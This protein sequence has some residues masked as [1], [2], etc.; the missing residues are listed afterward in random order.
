MAAVERPA[1]R[2]RDGWL[3]WCGIT[4]ECWSWPC[5]SPTSPGAARAGAGWRPPAGT[6]TSRCGWIPRRPC[7]CCS[8]RCS[9]CSPGRCGHGPRWSSSTWRWRRRCTTG[10]RATCCRS[11][12]S[13]SMR[14]I[15]GCSSSPPARSRW[16][17][18]CAGAGTCSC[19]G[20]SR[21]AGSR[22]AT[23]R[24]SNSCSGRGRSAATAS[25][26]KPA[27]ASPA[28][29][30]PARWCSSACSRGCCCACGR[31]NATAT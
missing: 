18:R 5:W 12:P 7:W 20:P 1:Q 16:H 19:R 30:Q 26:S 22:A 24:S 17:W 15:P 11:S 6:A 10:F 27:S 3:N 21:W 9:C 23:R 29:M 2:E 13:S 25:S 8:R 28:V 4:G 14:A 31:R